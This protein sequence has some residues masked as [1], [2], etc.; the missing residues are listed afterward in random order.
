[1]PLNKYA[2]CICT[3]VPLHFYCSLHIDSTL[4]PMSS[5]KQYIATSINHITA[6]Y[7]PGINMPPKCQI[8]TICQNYLIC[9]HEG[10]C[11]YAINKLIGINH[12]NRSTVHK[13]PMMIKVMHD[14]DA[15]AQ[16]HILSWLLSQISQKKTLT[17]NNGNMQISIHEINRKKHNHLLNYFQYLSDRRHLNVGSN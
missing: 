5:K 7:V 4:P 8:Y 12:V 13:T 15:Q 10:S 2:C 9:I 11:K 17:C 16:L 14:D 1:M 6:K 3:Y